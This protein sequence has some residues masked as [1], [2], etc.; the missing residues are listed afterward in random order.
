MEYIN[1]VLEFMNDYC[2]YVLPAIAA[3]LLIFAI[4][5]WS[6]NV[7][8]RQNK[9]LAYCA[10]IIAAYPNKAGIYANLLPDTY[11]RQWRAF[12]NSGA[13]RPSDVFEFVPMRGKFHLVW[14]MVITAALSTAYIAVFV[15][16]NAQIGYIL[17]QV[18]FWL[19]FGLIMVANK[20]IR[21]KNERRAK[22]LFGKL[23]ALL[24]RAASLPK[25]DDATIEET[26]AKLNNLKKNEVSDVV[27]GEASALL[28]NK[29][30]DGN[31]T[32]EQQKKLNTALNGL[33]Q[34]YARNASKIS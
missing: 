18:A 12:V 20:A 9:K 31:R 1:F 4:V 14:L 29:G 3:M 7:Y 25:S 27:V 23:V 24:N 16:T 22:Q 33:L 34:A 28:R 8:R 2:V 13:S 19:A 15:L 21:R 26:V 17:Y 5:N 6:S 11:R 10:R 32:V 30:L